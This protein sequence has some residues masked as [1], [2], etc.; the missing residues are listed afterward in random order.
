[1]YIQDQFYPDD[2]IW[3]CGAPYHVLFVEL[4]LLC[5]LSQED[6]DDNI[7]TLDENPGEQIPSSSK[8]FMF[9]W[10]WSAFKIMVGPFLLT[11]TDKVLKGT[12]EGETNVDS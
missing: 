5:L 1:M 8:S 3:T 7:V 11:C 2:L 6:A 10:K 9:W 12:F 4:P